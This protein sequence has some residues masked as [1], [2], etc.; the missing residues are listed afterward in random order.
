MKSAAVV[1]LNIVLLGFYIFCHSAVQP[2]LKGKDSICHVQ[3][4]TG[5]R[6]VA[7]ALLILKI[8]ETE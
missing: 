3:M 4:V 5:E 2:L 6:P 7:N 8:C 1:I